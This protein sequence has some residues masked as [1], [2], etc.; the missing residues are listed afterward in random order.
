MGIRI[1]WDDDERTIIR[2]VYEGDWTLEDYYHL[3][4]E[5][6]R[7]LDEVGHPVY[8]INDLRAMTSMP[9]DMAMAIRYAVH[10]AHPNEVIN[11]MV[12]ASMYVNMLVDAINKSI[13]GK[14][15]EVNYVN[16]LEEAYT[17]IENH[18]KTHSTA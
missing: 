2:H 3:I 13:K 15:T 9:Q 16:T 7:L 14:V 10:K 11:V 4:D 18:R 1:V 5:N 6:Y 12:G 8:I 17:M